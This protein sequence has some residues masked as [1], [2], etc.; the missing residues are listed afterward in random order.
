MTEPPRARLSVGR[1]L[2]RLEPLVLCARDRDPNLFAHLKKAA[3]V[4]KVGPPRR[5]SSTYTQAMDDSW[6]MKPCYDEAGRLSG[7]ATLYV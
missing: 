3:A 1:F 6:M 7:W 2:E 5:P 4:A